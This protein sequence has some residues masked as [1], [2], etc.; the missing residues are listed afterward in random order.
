LWG[1]VI[2]LNCL[3]EFSEEVVDRVER[4]LNTEQ[5]K[6]PVLLKPCSADSGRVT[7]AGWIVDKGPICHLVPKELFSDPSRSGELD[8]AVAEFIRLLQA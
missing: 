3:T 6:M 4:K 2:L 7:M 1:L 8:Q 5:L